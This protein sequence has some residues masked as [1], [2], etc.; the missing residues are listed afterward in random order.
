MNNNKLNYYNN[1]DYIE[2]MNYMN[3]KKIVNSK[4]NIKNN[5]KNSIKD[6]N[7]LISFIKSNKNMHIIIKVGASWCGPCKKMK[8]QFN[9]L[10]NYL[11]KKYEKKIVYLEMDLDN[12]KD[13]CSYLRVKGVPNILYYKNGVVNQSMVGYKEDSLNKLFSYIERNITIYNK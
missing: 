6:R 11:I 12:D 5:I 13:C 1:I 8:P 2:D 7:D 10:L 3:N 4:N 9:K